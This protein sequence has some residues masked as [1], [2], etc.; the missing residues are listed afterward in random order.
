MASGYVSFLVNGVNMANVPV[1]DGV[2]EFH[3]SP[4][5]P[6]SNVSV[7]ADFVG[8]PGYLNSIYQD[9]NYTVNQ[10]QALTSS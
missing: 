10:A 4:S 2:A 9:L 5:Y 3:L 8:N 7:R 1:V 6:G